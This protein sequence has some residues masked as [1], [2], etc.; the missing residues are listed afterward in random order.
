MA[1]TN[2]QDHDMD[3]LT[4]GLSATQIAER[5]AR[6]KTEP[7][8]YHGHTLTKD[9]PFREVCEA[10]VLSAFKASDLPVIVSLEH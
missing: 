3:D 8:V 1:R 10:I 4:R 2:Y 7:K 5:R 6:L 9:I